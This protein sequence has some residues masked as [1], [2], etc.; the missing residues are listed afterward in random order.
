MKSVTKPSKNMI[1]R[2][3]FREVPKR[4]ILINAILTGICTI[5]VLAAYYS[6]L[7]VPPEHQLATTASSGMI[8]GVATILLTLFVDPKSAVI[9]DQALR[10]ARPYGDVKALVIMLIASK[11]IGTLLGQLFFLPATHIIAYFY[12]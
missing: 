8:N 1:H 6:A 10:G 11:L 3:R 4:L 9:T 2:L 5:G 12:Q 7:L